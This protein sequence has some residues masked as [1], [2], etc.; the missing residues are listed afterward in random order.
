MFRGS[1][2]RDDKGYRNEISSVRL[3]RIFFAKGGGEAAG[4]ADIPYIMGLS[5]IIR[6]MVGI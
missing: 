4:V 2:D 5:D 3:M 6:Q 1:C